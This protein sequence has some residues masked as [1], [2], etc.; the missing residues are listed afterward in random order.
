MGG[1]DCSGGTSGASGAGQ[2]FKI[3]SDQEGFA[4]DS[5][6]KDVSGVGDARRAG[7]VDSRLRNALEEGS[8]EIVAQRGDPRCVMFERCGGEL[9]GF[10]KTDDAR[11][12]F[13]SGTEATLVM[14]AEK[15]L[16]QWC[17]TTN[18]EGA[19]SFGTVNFVS[20]ERKQIDL[21]G[22]YVDW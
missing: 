21:Q 4:V 15:E 19:N 17:A 6:K 20:G 13:G 16:A 5:G 11:D 22:V 1:F 10:T 7:A 9:G 18:V 12:I 3:K 14:A 2:A 8:L